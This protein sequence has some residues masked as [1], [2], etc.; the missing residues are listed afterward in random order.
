MRNNTHEYV[1]EIMDEFITS[2]NLRIQHSP[3]YNED[4]LWILE[5]VTFLNASDLGRLVKFYRVLD[6]VIGVEDDIDPMVED[7]MGALYCINTYNFIMHFDDNVTPEAIGN[8]IM[9]PTYHPV[10]GF[11]I[12]NQN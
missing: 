4:T 8:A 1:K 2:E 10:T 5:T 9:D 12:G 11:I 6:K 7:A 3:D